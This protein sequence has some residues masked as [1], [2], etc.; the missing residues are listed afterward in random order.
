MRVF[1][2]VACAAVAAAFLAVLTVRAAGRAGQ[3][4]SS[5][6]AQDSPPERAARARPVYS[7]SGYD[8]TP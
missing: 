1:G 5:S 2:P 8:M 6:P 7:K 4:A 3:R